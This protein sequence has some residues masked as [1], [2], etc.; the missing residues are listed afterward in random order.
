MK[1]VLH[2]ALLLCLCP[3]PAMA[4]PAGVSVSDDTGA[5]I[6]L[7]QPARRIISLAPHATEMLYAI[8]A[9]GRLVGATNYSDWPDAARRLPRVG[10][11]SGVSVEKVMAL[12]PDLVVGWASGNAP[13]ELARIRALGIPVYLTEPDSLDTV[14]A[15]ME[16]LGILSGFS[17]G[18]RRQ[19]AAF[20]TRI[21]ALRER[22]AGLTPLPVFIQI[23]VSPLMTVNGRQFISALVA[24]CGG[25]NVFAALAPRVPQVGVEAVM[26][27]RPAVMLVPGDVDRLAAWKRWTTI[28]AVANGQLYGLPE[29]LV[30]RPGPRLADGASAVCRVLDSARSRS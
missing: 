3:L 15:S 2:V 27:A 11:Y 26:A 1:R 6:S 16:K 17:D 7:P 22:H 20:R 12:K 25:R 21:A 29:D 9:G 5:S 18:G 4:T 30:S 10:G 14:P 24:L 23:N 13:R 19:A 8:G 28:P